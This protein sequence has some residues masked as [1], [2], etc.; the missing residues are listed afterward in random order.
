MRAW[1]GPAGNS[2]NVTSTCAQWCAGAG[3]ETTSLHR[4]LRGSRRS[5][6]DSE[7]DGRQDGLSK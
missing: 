5:D 4:L 3:N 2:G 6:Q 1:S 7:D